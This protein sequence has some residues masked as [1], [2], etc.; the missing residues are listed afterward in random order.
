[1]DAGDVGEDG[2]ILHANVRELEVLE[3]RNAF[4]AGHGRLILNAAAENIDAQKPARRAG[5]VQVVGDDVFDE[6]ASARTALD[7]D[8]EGLGAG[9][10]AVLDADV[11]NAARSLAADADAGED[12]IREGAI[13]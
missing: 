11:A 4:V 10:L 13:A 1:M 12:G 5:D 3:R 6:R 8:R 9:E 7:V 2:A